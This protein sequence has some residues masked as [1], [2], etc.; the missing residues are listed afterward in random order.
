MKKIKNLVYIALLSLL[1]VS[2]EDNTESITNP[3][4]LNSP[5]EIKVGFTDDNAT[6][7]VTEGDTASFRLEMPNAVTGTVEVSIS[8][9]SSDGAVEATYPST[10]TFVDGQSAVL[11]DVTPTDDATV[12]TE[13]YTV[14]ITGI[15]VDLDSGGPYYVHTGENSRMIQVKD[16]PTPIV[17][18]AGD[19]VFNFTWSGSSDLDCRLLDNPPAFIYDTGYSTTPGETV[20]LVDGDPDGDYLFTV[21]PWTVSDAS[22]DYNIEVVAPTETRN[23]SGNFMNLTGGWSME[24]VV[25][26]I[27][28]TTSGATVTYTIN[29]L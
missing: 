27:N 17:T 28:K 12:E 18:T 19:F 26:E 9:T 15:N 6:V 22:I 16:I 10:I 25:L 4:E 23:L 20:T 8:V 7:E 21:R 14:E 5:Q 13:V 1:V 11:F 2:C 24:F 3:G 29:Q